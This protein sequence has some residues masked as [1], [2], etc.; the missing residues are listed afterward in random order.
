MGFFFLKIA[1]DV[2]LIIIELTRV[3]VLDRSRT[4]ELQ[5]SRTAASSMPE[6]LK[7]VSERTVVR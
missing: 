7:K 6:K 5:I 1:F 4:E 2:W 3:Q